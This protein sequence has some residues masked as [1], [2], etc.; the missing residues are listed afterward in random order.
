M[1]DYCR[2]TLIHIC[3]H[4]SPEVV[5]A[6][7]AVRIT[8]HSDDSITA[9]G[10]KLSWRVA[11]LSSCPLK[12]L[13]DLDEGG[14]LV[15]PSYPHY[16]SSMD[17]KFVLTAKS[18]DHRIYLKFIEFDV[19][20]LPEDQKTCPSDFVEVY[21]GESFGLRRIC[22]DKDNIHFSRNLAYL[23]ES[24]YLS[25]TLKTANDPG[26]HKGY[27]ARYSVVRKYPYHLNIY[28]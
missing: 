21:L 5:S 12:E 22:G 10:F 17:C 19:G 15:S 18:S 13:T 23:S 9:K 28:L 6:G 7:N 11:D 26:T 1:N 24:N 8:F 20:Q 25:V 16:I 14:E 3:L 4:F 27:K 2:F